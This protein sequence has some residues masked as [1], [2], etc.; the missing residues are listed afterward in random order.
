MG[1]SEATQIPDM[2]NHAETMSS[3]KVKSQ[4][5]EVKDERNLFAHC[6]IVARPRPE[7]YV[8]E[9]LGNHKL[10]TQ[11][12]ALLIGAGNLFL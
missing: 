10:S 3:Q 5:N 11:P 4:D 8:K 9:A 1:S 6:M 7:I 12:M 2:E